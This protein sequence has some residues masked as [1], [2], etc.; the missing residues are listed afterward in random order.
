MIW[1]YGSKHDTNYVILMTN[2][3]ISDGRKRIVSYCDLTQAGKFV[4]SPTTG[5]RDV[6]PVLVFSSAVKFGDPNMGQT[7]TARCRTSD[8]RC[9]PQ[10]VGGTSY[11]VW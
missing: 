2:F 8:M 5:P 10:G 7:G 9:Q 3:V 4:T 6:A 11:G 1:F